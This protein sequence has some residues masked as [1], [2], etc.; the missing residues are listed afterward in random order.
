MK[1]ASTSIIQTIN[2]LTSNEDYRQDLWVYYLE[3][4]ST[5]SFDDFLEYLRLHSKEHKNSKQFLRDYIKDGYDIHEFLLNFTEFER[6]IIYLMVI[7]FTV[8]EIAKYKGISKIRIM[9]TINVIRD[10]PAW[11]QLREKVNGSKKKLNGT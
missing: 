10:N 8:P 5:L 4:N 11:E 7:N 6:S 9:Q 3:N 1:K 2:N